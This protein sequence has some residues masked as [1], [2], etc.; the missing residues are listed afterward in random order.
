MRLWCSLVALASAIALAACGATTLDTAELEDE[1]AAG[2]EKQTATSAVE[3]DCPNDIEQEKGLTTECKVSARGG[4][5]ATIV[6]TQT[7]DDGNVDWRLV[8]R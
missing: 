3:V 2:I 7:D 8:D 5:Q 4:V 6:A 1:I